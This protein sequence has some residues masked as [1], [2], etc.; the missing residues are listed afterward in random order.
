MKITYY[1]H[2]CILAEH[3]G[4][5]VLIDPFLSENPLS[6]IKPDEIGTDA[7]VL[8][9]AHGDHFGDTLTIARR[10]HCPVIAVFEL[11]MYCQQKGVKTHAMNIG[12]AYCFPGFRVKYTPAFHSSS[13]AEGD[14]FLYAGQPAGV[15]LTMGDKTLYHA[16]DTCLFSDMRLIGERNAIDAAA[17]PIGDNFTMGPEEALLAAQ[18]IK[19][20]HV[21][22]VHYNTFPVIHQDPL[23]FTA[24]LAEV[25][26]QGHPLKSGESLEL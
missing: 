7:I 6:G 22:P 8:T 5:R 19:T 9:H 3:E 11:A 12:G 2:S 10:N 17:L 21:I 23:K 26:I 1:G 4:T 13:I 18:W 25:G 24:A 15:L 16:G 14:Q 20:K